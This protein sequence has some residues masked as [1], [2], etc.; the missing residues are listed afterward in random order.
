VSVKCG[1][2][3]DA[4]FAVPFAQASCVKMTN[5]NIRPLVRS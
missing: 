3:V 2:M 5:L 4:F 1:I